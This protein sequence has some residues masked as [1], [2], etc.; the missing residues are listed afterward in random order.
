MGC[1]GLQVGSRI[2]RLGTQ[3][4]SSSKDLFE[5][6]AEAVQSEL[7]NLEGHVRKPVIS[8]RASGARYIPLVTS[9]AISN[10]ATQ[11]DL[12]HEAGSI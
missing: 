4:L 6:V 5:Q 7:D 9:P 10:Q 2:G 8:K 11:H 12:A 1:V 3:V